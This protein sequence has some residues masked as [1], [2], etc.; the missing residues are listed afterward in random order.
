MTL[1]RTHADPTHWLEDT[2]A[3]GDL[4]PLPP[5]EHL[6]PQ[7]DGS[8]PAATT[9]W[10]EPLNR[11]EEP[12][13]KAMAE[14][15]SGRISASR[16]PIRVARQDTFVALQMWE[17]VVETVGKETFAA[18]LVARSGNSPDHHAEI[19][20][21]DLSESDRRLLAPGAV[22]YWSIGYLDTLTGQRKK[23]SIIRFRAL[24]RWTASDIERGKLRAS[25]LYEFLHGSD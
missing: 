1:A 5:F 22:F 10:D 6:N 21:E 17:G 20:V 9:V 16:T 12:L 11:A 14:R 7:A 2:K 8:P 4:P 23:E 19:Y 18:K 3:T 15:V 13:G 24:P 25:E